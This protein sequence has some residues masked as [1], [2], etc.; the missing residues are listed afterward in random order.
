[1]EDRQKGTWH[2]VRS[3]KGRKGRKS[4]RLTSFSELRYSQNMQQIRPLVIICLGVAFLGLGCGPREPSYIPAEEQ[5]PIQVEPNAEG[6]KASTGGESATVTPELPTATLLAAFPQPKDG[7]SAGDA[8]ETK[9]PVPLPDGTR[10]EYTVLARNYEQEGP[11]VF[12]T[13]HA[14]LTDTRGIPALTAF[15]D[16]YFERS[17]DDGYRKKT[18]VA[19][20]SGWVTYSNSTPG[21]VDG[22]GSV[23]VLIHGRF[24]LQLDGGPGSTEEALLDL[25]NSFSREV[26]K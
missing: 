11:D 8:I 4:Y 3:E 10:A 2:I 6:G 1:M 24:L 25:A 7:W 12:Y 21:D 13:I 16:S 18:D 17:D 22:S 5:T 14:T 23:V 26:L 9:N 20:T 15:L 19:G